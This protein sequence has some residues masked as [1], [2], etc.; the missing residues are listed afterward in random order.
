M[1]SKFSGDLAVTGSD[2]AD[3]LLN[4]NPLALLLGMLL[5][6]QIPME[7]AFKGPYTLLERLGKLDASQIASM[8][9]EKFE[10]ICKEKPAI[11]RFPSSMAGRI[12]DLCE[13]L[14][15]NYNGDAEKLWGGSDSGEILYNRLIDLP[16]FGDEK[17][18]IFTALLAKR[19]DCAPP[20]WQKCAGP[21]ADKTPRSVADINSPESLTKVRAWKKA[22][23]AAGKSKQE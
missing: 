16:G 8:D 14:V 20:G 4:K 2:E 9:P 15:E 18:M 10:S 11:H 22:Q 7:W 23:K 1:T 12:Q 5:D 3:Q 17:S 13:H 21:F 6:Q 19:M